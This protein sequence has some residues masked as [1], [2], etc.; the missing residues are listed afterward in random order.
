MSPPDPV[1]P[2]IAYYSVDGGPAIEALGPGQR[3]VN[4]DIEDDIALSWTE[5]D[6]VPSDAR[7]LTFTITRM[8]EWQGPWEFVIVLQD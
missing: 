1:L 3:Y 4:H 5:L 6:P 7:I 8:G 2:V